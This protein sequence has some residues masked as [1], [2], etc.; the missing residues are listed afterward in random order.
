MIDVVTCLFEE[1]MEFCSS[2]LG[3]VDRIVDTFCLVCREI[4]ADEI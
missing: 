4:V 3:D 2:L 1:R